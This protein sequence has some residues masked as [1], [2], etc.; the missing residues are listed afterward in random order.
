MQIANHSGRIPMLTRVAHDAQET[1]EQGL[2]HFVL[3]R[4]LG[5]AQV[6][7]VTTVLLNDSLGSEQY[8]QTKSS[9][10]RR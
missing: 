7:Y 1:Q 5:H 6:M 8:Q 3:H 2:N 9:I 4:V 10:E